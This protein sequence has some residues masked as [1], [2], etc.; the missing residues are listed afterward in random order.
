MTKKKE[1][2]EMKELNEYHAKKNNLEVT[3]M[4]IDEYLQV[5]NKTKN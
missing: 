5:D 1:S 4:I 2:K 3:K